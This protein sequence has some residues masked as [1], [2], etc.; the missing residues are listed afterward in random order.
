[1]IKINEN[2]LR[3]ELV[4][5]QASL[6]Q[7]GGWSRMEAVARCLHWLGE[8]EAVDYFYRAATAY[9]LGKEAEPID[10]L[11]VGTLLYLAN[12]IPASRP[13]YE[14]ARALAQHKIA[15]KQWL[16]YQ[17]L[18]PSCF[19]LGLDDE[20]QSYARSFRR[21]EPNP[22]L[23]INYVVMLAEA[24]QTHNA[25]RALDSAESIANAIRKHRAK[26]IDAGAPTPWDWYEI[27]LRLAK[28][29]GA[30]VPAEAL[31]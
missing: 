5:L 17:Q 10:F 31:P 18:V 29:L 25:K 11:R 13:Y 7:Y 6:M 8:A 12:D 2:K 24:R 27:A 20:A 28:E 4:K 14:K 15:Q 1:M 30:A 26:I 3:Q 21:Q 22:E 16:V 23:M 9:P 19:F